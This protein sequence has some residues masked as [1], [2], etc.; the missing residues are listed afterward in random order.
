MLLQNYSKF[1]QNLSKTK[2]NVN[3]AGS[4]AEHLLLLQRKEDKREKSA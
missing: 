4:S 2:G 1:K 3:L